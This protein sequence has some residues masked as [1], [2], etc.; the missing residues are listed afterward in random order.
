MVQ[1]LVV[2]LKPAPRLGALFQ[3]AG[4]PGLGC[5]AAALLLA[6]GVSGCGKDGSDYF[7]LDPGYSWTYR[8]VLQTRNKGNAGAFEKNIYAVA[9]TNLPSEPLGDG[10]AVP[11]LY[12]DGGTLYFA[13]PADGIALVARRAEDQ[14][15]PMP[16]APRYILK[17]PLA[18]G[19]SWTEPG[20]TQ[21]LRRTIL[22]SF[23]Q[24]TKSISADGPLTYKVES[25]DDSVRVK[26][27]TFHHCI[28][29]HGT[30][31]AKLD[32]ADSGVLP[33]AIDTVEWYAPGVGLVKRI[34]KEDSGADGP[35]GADLDEELESLTRPGWFG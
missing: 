11:R 18:V 23:G 24:F 10:R 3:G 2:Q 34:R 27:G 12:N 19:D 16:I 15:Q 17:H 4:R 32:W 33:I 28:R 31:N 20:E 25:L 21:I 35:L 29:L 13:K 5:L 8:Q 14:D 6:A 9:E 22:G 1:G 26:A 30:G 7:P